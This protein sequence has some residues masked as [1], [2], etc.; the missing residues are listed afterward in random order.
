MRQDRRYTIEHAN[1]AK[2]KGLIS[3]LVKKAP[4]RDYLKMDKEDLIKEIQTL[5][6]QK[7][8]GLV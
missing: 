4:Q 2:E 5:K 3:E 1:L 8:F 7:K 6:S